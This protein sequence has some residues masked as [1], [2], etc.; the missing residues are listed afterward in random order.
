MTT[1]LFTEEKSIYHTMGC[2]CYDEK[3]NALTYTGEKAFICHP[4]CRTWGRLYKQTGLHPGEHL[5]SVWS[6]LKIWKN[7]GVLEHPAGSKLWKLMKL[8][9]P[10][11]GV[12]SHNGWS[13]SIDQHWFGHKAKK[14]TWLYIRGVPPGEIPSYPINLN[15]ITHCIAA[16]KSDS[17]LKLLDK[18]QYSKTPVQLAEFLIQLTEI[19]NNK[20]LQK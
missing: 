19:I 7:G 15:L 20:K 6:I 2:D 13:L 18:K 1:V 11:S 12:D 14:N 10:G 16:H 3:R 17:G 8:P 4:P 5:L 9:A